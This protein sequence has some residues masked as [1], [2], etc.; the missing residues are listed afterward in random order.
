MITVYLLIPSWTYGFISGWAARLLI[1]L[2]LW[3]WVDINDEIK[4]L[5]PT[6]LKLAI[7][8][9]RW[10]I[11]FYCLL[12][13]I[14]FLPFLSCALADS[15]VKQPFCQVWL[16]P[17]WSYHNIFHADADP[18]VLGFIGMVGLAIYIVYLAYFVCIRLGKQGRSALEQ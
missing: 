8:A 9:W 18:N 13:A 11:T 16:E 15:N 3:F 6:P 12:G 5:P 10:A 4:D 1:P 2:S 7:T 17:P 14:A